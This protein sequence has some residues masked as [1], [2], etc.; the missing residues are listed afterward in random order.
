VSE[1]ATQED[2]APTEATRREG[3]ASSRPRKPDE[4]L[5]RGT[6]VGRYVVLD[7]LGEGGMGVVYAAFDPELDRKVAVKL[8]QS[9]EQE[10]LLREAQALAR[11]THPNVIAVFDVGTL[12]GDRVFV[13]MELVEGETL[14]AWLRARKRTWREVLPVLRAA[15]AGLAAAHA[16]GLVHG[17]FKPENV[18]VGK[19]GRVRVLDFGLARRLDDT[20]SPAH[21]LASDGYVAGTPAY[22]APELYDQ[23]VADARSDQ[24]AFGVAL[25]EAVY[26]QRPFGKDA[27]R[28]LRPPPEGS[29]V[30]ARGHRVILRAL[31]TDPAAR[32]PAMDALLAELEI[33]P[34][35]ARRRVALAVGAAV[36]AAG[37][38]GAVL[39]MRT[40]GPRC[41]GAQQRLAGVWDAPVKTKVEAAFAA[42]KRP[43]AASSFA[44]LSRALDQYTHDWSAA[45]TDACEATR[46]RG[47]QNDYV[48]SLRE[49]CLDQ[50]LAELRALS[51]L[52]ASADADLVEKGDKVAYGLES[53]EPCA[54]VTALLQ[55]GKRPT[56]PKDVIATYDRELAEARAQMLAGHGLAAMTA[57]KHAADAA[58]AVHD[59]A[60][61]AAPLM[62]R[63]V[64]LESVGNFTESVATF[65]EATW[66]AM[67]GK[68]DEL[69]AQSALA[70]AGAVLPLDRPGEA[71]LWLGFAAAMGHRVGVDHNLE[72]HRLD[73]EGYL[74]LQDH[75][76]DG[77]LRM[78]EKAI[79]EAELSLGHDSPG[80]W[81]EEEI[82]GG[83]LTQIGRFGDA[84]P[85]FER[86][87]ALHEK[88]VGPDHPEIALILTTL[89]V[90]YR[91]VGQDAKALAAYERAL[92]IRE[93][94]Y[95][96]NSP[97]LVATINNLAD[98]H[99][100]H[101]DIP[102]ALQMI[103]R[104]RT[105]SLPMGK[106]QQGYQIVET[107]YAETLVAA[108]RLPEAH[109]VFDELIA[110]EDRLKS[111]VLPTTLGS[112]AALA[113]IEKDWK[114][115]IANAERAVGL[116]EVQSGKDTG[117]LVA[118]LTAL[119]QARLA[120][121]QR[122]A[123]RDAL[124]RALAIGAR[125]KLGDDALA[126]ARKA[127]A[128]LP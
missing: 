95:G 127:R 52:L 40:S 70:A 27:P 22:L 85:H 94:V 33:D 1:D 36:I 6:L 114:T 28:T 26:G 51:A 83:T 64:V 76:I 31:S 23:K 25:Y 63:A 111:Q 20:E 35:A 102:G 55:P 109:G 2:A 120:L 5:S 87:L 74:L 128:S 16:A 18:L 61:L 21:E 14:R 69:A 13:A 11:I 30:P 100:L 92:A 89:G 75:D 104:A 34:G 80:V 62:V 72:Q 29:R 88:S 19:D 37:A 96:K 107:T 93:R 117:D 115:A 38:T 77:A 110:L 50:R 58:T 47:E 79:A 105:I 32:Y 103:E 90:C 118:P 82:Y 122:D 49:A 59:D 126:P 17:D 84:V 68:H 10:V 73:I 66:A 60:M 81:S 9:R 4:R 119:G 56:E 44:G 99:R 97:M 41:E 113:V 86:A 54:N 98:Y 116:F 125:V 48:M 112:R 3:P 71:K 78:H 57:A 121:G 53:L 7:V 45:V 124:D 42:T 106:Q 91:Q 12:P 46:V 108:G 123:A 39:S 65:Q 8:L 15:G 43:F 101:G 67:R 24:F